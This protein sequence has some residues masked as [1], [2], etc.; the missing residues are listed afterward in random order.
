[1]VPLLLIVLILLLLVVIL[2]QILWRPSQDSSRTLQTLLTRSEQQQAEQRRYEDLLRSES[3]QSRL[4]AGTLARENRGELLETIQKL[5]SSIL[6][7]LAENQ[8]NHQENL[9]TMH[10]LLAESNT[11]LR[12]LLER[13]LVGLQE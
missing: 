7:P 10:K 11:Q 6:T 4:E 13:R 1:M 8:R 3:A 5:S 9:Q 12:D 2:L